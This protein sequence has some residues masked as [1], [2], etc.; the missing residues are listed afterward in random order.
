MRG[1]EATNM[2]T[3]DGARIDVHL[4]LG[5][6]NEGHLWLGI[7]DSTGRRALLFLSPEEVAE[8]VRE[9][10]EPRRS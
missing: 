7:E 2:Q 10:G 8:L 9:L 6:G 1:Q 3:H 4:A 5:K